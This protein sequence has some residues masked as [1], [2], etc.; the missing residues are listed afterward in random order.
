MKKI[1]F[2]LA[3]LPMMCF[4]K[5]SIKV[6]DVIVQSMRM[7]KVSPSDIL[8]YRQYTTR[9]IESDGFGITISPSVSKIFY[10]YGKKT[11]EIEYTID[12]LTLSPRPISIAKGARLLLKKKDGNNIV[13]KSKADMEDV[14]GED[15]IY[16]NT[17]HISCMFTVTLSQLNEIANGNISKIRIEYTTSYKDVVFN[18]NR[19]SNYIKEAI[20]RITKAEKIKDNFLEGF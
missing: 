14:I 12:I 15:F 18:D 3:M 8:N 11:Q 16:G 4:G 10:D 9:S 20:N 19:L 17:Y 13:L 5:D 2:F 6:K 7:I 1:L